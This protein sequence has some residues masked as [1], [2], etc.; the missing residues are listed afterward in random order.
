MERKPKRPHLRQIRNRNKVAVLHILR[1]G[2]F[3]SRP[4][5]AESL[6]V[7]MMSVSRL[8]KELVTEGICLTDEGANKRGS[9]GRRPSFISLNP[10]YG[11][12]LIHI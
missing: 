6:G 4:Q 5:M 10:S 7:S 3:V 12:S 1:G 9:L 8:V 11:L 2:G